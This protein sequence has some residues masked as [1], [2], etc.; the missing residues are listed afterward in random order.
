MP[1]FDTV[2]E[3][4]LVEVRNAVDQT[5]N[6][7]VASVQV[8]FGFAN[9]NAADLT[10]ASVDDTTILLARSFPDL[11]GQTVSGSFEVD[12]NVVSGQT[13]G[14]AADNSIFLRSTGLSMNG[15]WC[16]VSTKPGQMALTRTP[17]GERPAASDR[18]SATMP[19]LAAV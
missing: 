10:T 18:V 9:G 14:N 17:S 1:S 13:L 3:P 12:G 19:P 6:F 15:A 11:A 4:N 5:A 2:L 7:N 16:G 8:N